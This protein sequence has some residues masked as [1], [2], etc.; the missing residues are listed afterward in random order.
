MSGASVERLTSDA[1][2]GLANT[3]VL[4]LPTPLRPKVPPGRPAL[5]GVHGV[6]E[7]ARQELPGAPSGLLCTSVLLGRAWGSAR[8]LRRSH[9]FVDATQS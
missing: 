8:C 1:R 7:D 4:C 3:H 2:I 6:Q 5:A 9:C